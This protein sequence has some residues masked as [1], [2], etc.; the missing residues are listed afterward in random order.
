M[1]RDIVI[2]ISPKE[3]YLPLYEHPSTVND[4][5]GGRGRGGSHEA[6]LYALYRLT[7]PDY[8]RIAFVRKILNDVRHSLWKDFKD[9]IEECSIPPEDIHIA[10]N[11]MQATCTFTG[12]TVNCFGVKAE[13]GRTAK[14]KSLAGY[15]LVIVEECDELTEEEFNQLDDSLRTVKG[16]E[17]PMVI[18]VFNPPGRNHWIWNN[19]NLTEA[20]IEGYWQAKPKETSGIL[21]IFG[22]FLNNITNLDSTKVEKWR[23]YE[24][25]NPEYFH[26]IICGLISEGQRGRVYAGWMPITMQQFIDV[27]AREIFGQDFGT[28][29]PAANGSMKIV[30]NK[31]YIR[32]FNYK[33]LTD[34][35][36][37]MLYCKLGITGSN[38]I[39][40]DKEDPISI[41]K[42]RNGWD[43]NS[44]SETEL[45]LYP[46][47]VKGFY[48][49]A[50]IGG[51]GSIDF[52]IKAVKDME[53]FVVEDSINIWNEYRGYKWALDKDKNP[54]NTPEDKNNHHMDWIRN[55]ITAKGR[56]F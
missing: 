5:W 2:D 11:A 31:A 17:R 16:E 33:P 55:V 14:L 56:L 45:Q 52:G 28:V 10:D 37:G 1:T 36:I 8:C 24:K 40:A 54:T 51:P 50:S 22:T 15:N 38:L 23:S 26:T 53:V 39:I 21:S 43:K 12:N 13:G 41:N 30:K 6:T 9:R 44:L 48:I 27:D 29:D 7:R 3:D 46:Q 35:E 32:E 19:Y 42:L 34:K 18:R 20:G 25:S 47:L 49:L 4:L